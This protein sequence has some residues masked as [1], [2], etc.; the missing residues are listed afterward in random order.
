MQ[1][2]AFVQDNDEMPMGGISSFSNVRLSYDPNG[3]LEHVPYEATYQFEGACL[4]DDV[5]PVTEEECLVAAK[6]SKYGKKKKA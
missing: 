6:M 5:V 2:V 1:Y 3:L 4:A